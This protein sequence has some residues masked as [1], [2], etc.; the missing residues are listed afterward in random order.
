MAGVVV[1]FNPM[2]TFTDDDVGKN[3]FVDDEQVGTVSE[4]RDGVAYVEP[5]TMLEESFPGELA[6]GKADEDSYP[7]PDDA[8]SEITDDEIRLTTT[9]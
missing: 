6:L 1:P 3:V 2:A 7:V 4:V 8:I 5:N 9:A